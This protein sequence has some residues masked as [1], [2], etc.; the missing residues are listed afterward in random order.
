MWK[1]GGGTK[2]PPVAW[3][4]SF[5][6]SRHHAETEPVTRA[7]KRF[8][9]RGRLHACLSGHLAAERGDRRRPP[10]PALRADDLPGRRGDPR[11]QGH[12]AP[13]RPPRSA[14]RR[15]RPRGEGRGRGRQYDAGARLALDRVFTAARISGTE[16]H[17][18]PTA[19]RRSEDS[20]LHPAHHPLLVKS[21][22][23]V[24]TPLQIA[25]DMVS[26]ASL[27][28]ESEICAYRAVV[29]GRL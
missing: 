4:Y 27:I 16:A 12:R 8:E 7:V 17:S 24:S 26:T 9:P 13:P 19:E 14:G 6:G 25:R 10:H 21:C 15:V 23:P 1:R 20:F 22:L 2:G 5:C 28:A 29:W 3:S 11:A 18:M